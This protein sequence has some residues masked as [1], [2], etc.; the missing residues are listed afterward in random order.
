MGLEVLGPELCAG[1][2]VATVSP[3]FIISFSLSNP[4]KDVARIVPTLARRMLRFGEVKCSLGFQSPRA[5]HQDPSLA[6]VEG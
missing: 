6:A 1:V 5:P 3:Y 4:E 2:A